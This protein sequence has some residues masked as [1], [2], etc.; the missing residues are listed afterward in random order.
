MIQESVYRSWSNYDLIK[1]ATVNREDYLPEGLAMIE[2]ELLR[3]NVVLEERSDIEQ[4]VHSD[5]TLRLQNLGRV[6]GW[7]LVFAIAVLVQSVF[8]ILLGIA[9]RE[10][11]LYLTLFVIFGAYGC[12]AFGLLLFKKS[13][14]PKHA[15]RWLM[16][17]FVL[18][19]IPLLLILLRLLIRSRIAVLPYLPATGNAGSEFNLVLIIIPALSWYMAWLWYLEK[20]ER[21]AA[22]YSQS[23]SGRSSD[24]PPTNAQ[25]SRGLSHNLVPGILVLLGCYKVIT[26]LT[27]IDTLV[28]GGEFRSMVGFF[29]GIS[30]IIAAFIIKRY[31]KRKRNSSTGQ[32]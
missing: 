24:T 30:L 22:T 17:G 10:V 13:N 14:A 5:R 31:L 9:M 29:F 8:S 18:T 21:V 27:S 15:A 6:R 12:Y 2:A 4:Q 3:R 19:L 16:A 20:S 23:V 11:P 26:S 28:E 7:L 32:E 25:S 1:A